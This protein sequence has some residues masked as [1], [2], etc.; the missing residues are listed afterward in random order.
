MTA[1][2]FCAKISAGDVERRWPAVVCFEPLNPVT[3]GHMLVVPVTHVADVGTDPR[4]SA[5]T[6][7]AAAELAGQLG[8][9]NIITSRGPAATQTVLHLHLHVVPRRPGD[10]LALPWT[11]LPS[12]HGKIPEV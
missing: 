1:C 8:D 6:M 7:A 11:P 2:V 3:P 9:C 4:W 5:V 10:G 12:V